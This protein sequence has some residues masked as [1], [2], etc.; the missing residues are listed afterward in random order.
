[1]P[2]WRRTFALPKLQGL[3]GLGLG[4]DL[5]STLNPKPLNPKPFY[6]GSSGAK[7]F[8]VGVRFGLYKQFS[9][10]EGFSGVLR[11]GDDFGGF[12]V[13]FFWGLRAVYRV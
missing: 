1:M 6:K 8:R 3:K 7:G 10:D 5:G 4:F 13:C 2:A 12:L 11:L 9:A